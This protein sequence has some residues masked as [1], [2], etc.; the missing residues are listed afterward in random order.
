MECHWWV[1]ITAQMWTHICSWSLCDESKYSQSQ[2]P[3]H[4]FVVFQYLRYSP[5]KCVDCLSSSERV[6][7]QMRSPVYFWYIWCYMQL[8]DLDIH[9]ASWQGRLLPPTFRRC[10]IPWWPPSHHIDPNLQVSGPKD[11]HHIGHLDLAILVKYLQTYLR[12]A[13][14]LVA[15]IPA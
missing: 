9:I 8:F 4:E 2:I 13:W 3:L 5:L 7:T 11:T 6:C 15:G 14:R 10:F 1:L 12:K